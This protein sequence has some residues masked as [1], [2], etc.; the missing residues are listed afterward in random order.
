MSLTIAEI[1]TKTRESKRLISKAR[2]TRRKELERDSW[3]ASA[4]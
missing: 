1:E 3:A 4:A 2:G